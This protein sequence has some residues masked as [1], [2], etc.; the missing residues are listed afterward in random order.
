MSITWYGTCACEATREARIPAQ[1]VGRHHDPKAILEPS[2]LWQLSWGLECEPVQ[3]CLSI[4]TSCYGNSCYLL[5]KLLNKSLASLLL[6]PISFYTVLK[7]LPS[8]KGWG[9]RVAVSF[10][11]CLGASAPT[12]TGQSAPEV[13]ATWRRRRQL[14]WCLDILLA[15]ACSLRGDGLRPDRNSL[16]TWLIFTS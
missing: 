9:L 3:R 14:F 12:F 11:R 16:P 10:P 6:Y 4:C 1:G 7:I 5:L 15:K 2:C 13:I 8:L